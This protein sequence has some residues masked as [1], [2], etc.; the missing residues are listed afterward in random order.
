MNLDDTL[1]KFFQTLHLHICNFIMQF[2]KLSL[3]HDLILCT[4]HNNTSHQSLHH[5]IIITDK[6]ILVV[7]QHPESM[8]Y[9]YNQPGV[10][11]HIDTYNKIFREHSSFSSSQYVLPLAKHKHGNFSH[12]HM[13]QYPQQTIF[14]MYVHWAKKPLSTS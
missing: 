7:S 12:F 13:L 2:R 4:E 8:M 11:E 9:I 1:L 10:T 3:K 5:T 6:N 14:Y